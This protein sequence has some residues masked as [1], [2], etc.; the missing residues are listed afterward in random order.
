MLHT[1]VIYI[2]GTT[3]MVAITVFIVIIAMKLQLFTIV[4]FSHRK[5][6]GAHIHQI[7]QSFILINRRP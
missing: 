5:T 3:L 7:F 4:I 6:G 2:R 1:G